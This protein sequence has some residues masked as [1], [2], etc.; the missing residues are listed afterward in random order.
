MYL[1][2]V[3]SFSAIFIVAY[4]IT[5]LFFDN[6]GSA[7]V[8]LHSGLLYLLPTL[9]GAL[10]IL[11]PYVLI[12]FA[13]ITVLISVLIYIF[14]RESY[15]KSVRFNLISINYCARPVI[16]EVL[17]VVIPCHCIVFVDFYLC[18]AIS[19]AKDSPFSD[20]PH[21]WDVVEYHFPTLN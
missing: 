18:G 9:A 19:T 8:I 11:R 1:L 7:I 13:L 15:D 2:L 10:G 14:K 3:I 16:L 12:T 4:I 20:S 17:L 6:R 5:K 21:V